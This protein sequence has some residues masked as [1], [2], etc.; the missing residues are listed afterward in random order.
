MRLD[1]YLVG[2]HA[3]YSRNKAQ[4]MIKAG[5]VAVDGRIIMKPSF[6]VDGNDVKVVANDRYVSRAALKL[7]SFLPSLPFDISGCEA[8]DIGAS[9]GGFTQVL[10]EEGALHVVAVDVGRDQLHPKLKDD[11]RVT[12]V[13][14][15]DIR[16]YEAKKKFDIVVSDVSFISL[17]HILEEIDRLASRWIIVL[18]KPQFEV[19]REVKRDKNGVVNDKKAIE[20]AMLKFEDACRVRRWELTA[21]EASSL[22]G[23]EG[24]IE[25]C[26]CF[27]KN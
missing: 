1:Q 21:K 11:S 27:R 6:Q 22:S 5:E 8:L 24:N 14:K 15:T 25:Y 2:R 9:T 10:L 18:F 23:K 3:L 17:L 12:S 19:G 4:E 13:E 20:R 7:K 16:K 26:Y